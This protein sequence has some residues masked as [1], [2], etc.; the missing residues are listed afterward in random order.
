MNH[1]INL[2]TKHFYPNLLKV[3]N[4]IVLSS[5]IT[6]QCLYKTNI[7]ES[8]LK[9]GYMQLCALKMNEGHMADLEVLVYL[10]Y[11]EFH[12]KYF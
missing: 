5:K 9:K 12:E 3:I 10:K 1:S 4:K 6:R 11:K 8:Q 2:Q 7:S